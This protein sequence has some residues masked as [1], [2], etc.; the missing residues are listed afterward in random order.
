MRPLSHSW[1]AVLLGVVALAGSGCMSAELARVHR[2]VERDLS[3]SANAP[4]R[5][6][7]GHAFQFGRLSVG[8][9]R[10][11]V[12]RDDPAAA[13]AL[14]AVRGVAVGTYP[15]RGALDPEALRLDG[16]SARIRGRGWE[17]VAVTRDSASATFV[18][19]RLSREALRDLL[20]VS[21]EDEEMT[22]VRVSGE[23]GEEA[24]RALAHSDDGLLGLRRAVLPV[25]NGRAEG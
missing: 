24:M 8:L 2:D 15:L 25:V 22:L 1:L 13:V 20:V 16:A 3:G 9:A 21:F 19:A 11:V 17:P 5:L 7:G 6:G 4:A 14:G 12:G 23:L 18:Y 10:R